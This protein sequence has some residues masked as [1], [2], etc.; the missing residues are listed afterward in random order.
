MAF[1]CVDRGISMAKG[2]VSVTGS[3]VVSRDRYGELHVRLLSK[4]Y[5]N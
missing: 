3:D 2:W 1:P 5:T 4:D